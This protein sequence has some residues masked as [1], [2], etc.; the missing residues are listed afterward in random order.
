MGGYGLSKVLVCI[1]PQ[2]NGKRLINRGY[3][4]SLSKSAELLILHVEQ[5]TS[6]FFFEDSSKLLEE[7]FSFGSERGGV[8]HAICGHD[9]FVTIKRFILENSISDVVMGESPQGTNPA[10]TIKD[11]LPHIN[12]HVVGRDDG[13]Y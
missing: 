6:V 10:L 7:L 12:V 11:D 13:N 1:T 3:E 2:A 8:I 9:P 5:N 4:I